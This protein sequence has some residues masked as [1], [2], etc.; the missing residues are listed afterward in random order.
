MRR[1]LVKATAAAIG[2]WLLNGSLLGVE[3]ANADDYKNGSE[4][5]TAGHPRGE[6]VAPKN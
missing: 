6:T 4:A 5:R 1:W 2:A 3:P